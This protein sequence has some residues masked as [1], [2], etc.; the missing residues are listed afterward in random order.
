MFVEQLPYSCG[1]Q[2][3]TRTFKHAPQGR[4]RI[5]RYTS[6][7]S[8]R[9]GMGYY[10]DIYFRRFIRKWKYHAVTKPRRLREKQ[11]SLYLHSKTIHDTL[12]MIGTF[13]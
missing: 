13:L 6:A 1:Y 3:T 9:E 7:F 12:R 4:I 2:L 11:M 10:G 8:P 5:A